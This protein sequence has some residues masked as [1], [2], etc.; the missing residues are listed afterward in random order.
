VNR[1]AGADSIVSEPLPDTPWPVVASNL[2]T[3]REQSLYERLLSLYP[4]H[5]IFVQVA[6]SQLIDV[7]EDQPERQSIR[8]RFSQLVADF[9]LCRPDLTVVAVIELDDRSHERRDRQDADA[10]KTK[11]LVDAGLRLVR[12]PAGNLPSKEE[13]REIID[14]DR[15]PSG[16]RSENPKMHS[17]AAEPELRLAG[18]WGSTHPDAPKVHHEREAMRALKVGALKMVLV[19]ILIVGGWFVYAHFIPAVVQRAFQPLVVGPVP[20]S[21]AVPHSSST[22]SVPWISTVPTQQELAEKRRAELRPAAD[23]QRQKDRAWL[24]YYSAPASCEHPVDWN[25]QVECG[26]QYMRA[27]KD[28]EKQWLADHPSGEFG[29]AAIVLDNGSIGGARK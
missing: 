22:G 20:N 25:A 21:P 27:K 7:P 8:N 4:N 23:L 13:L 28:F 5:R 2:L 10:R 12:I 29:G 11:A 19:G 1:R 18:D 26:N 24:A 15:V 17:F 3:R 6:L 9:V 16:D 14:A